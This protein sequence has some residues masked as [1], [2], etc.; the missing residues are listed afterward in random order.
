MTQLPDLNPL[1]RAIVLSIKDDS[2]PGIY[3]NYSDL[4]RSFV[5]LLLLAACLLGAWWVLSEKQQIDDRGIEEYRR[6][7]DRK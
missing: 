4:F 7:L 3:R 6:W 5:G 1:Q 2:K